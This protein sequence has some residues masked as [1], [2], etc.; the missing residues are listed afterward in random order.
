MSAPVPPAAFT[1]ALPLLP[2]LHVMFVCEA[3][4]TVAPPLLFTTTETVC[5]H[6]FASV[7]V[8]VYEPAAMFEIDEVVCPP[9]FQEYDKLPVPPLAV[10][11]AEPVFAPQLEFVL[12]VEVAI[13][14]GCV[15][16]TV[17]VVVHVPSFTETVYVPAGRFAAVAP[18]PPDGDQL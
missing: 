9:G 15:I 4:E 17:C 10:T 7:T 16:V 3:S 5:V 11:L 2:P 12:A 1:V 6:A 8:H 14:A 18:F 13:A